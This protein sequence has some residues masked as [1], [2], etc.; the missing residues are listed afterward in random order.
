MGSIRCESRTLPYASNA[1]YQAK[2][3]GDG[4]LQE[5]RDDV[6]RGIEDR[7]R[8]HAV[9][10]ILADELVDARVARAP[11]V[12]TRDGVGWAGRAGV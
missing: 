2:R 4:V 5:H 9:G 1:P 10:A 6:A 12:L 8:G 3:A 11:D 7:E